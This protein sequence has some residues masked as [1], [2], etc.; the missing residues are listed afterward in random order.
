MAYRKFKLAQSM[1]RSLGENQV[2]ALQS[3]S[4]EVNAFS[5]IYFVEGVGVSR[6]ARSSN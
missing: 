2:L 1:M 5:Y 6:S 4:D 3:L